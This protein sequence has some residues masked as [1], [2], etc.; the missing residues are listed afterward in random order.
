M[1]LSLL[2]V[3]FPEVRISRSFE[4]VR[5]DVRDYRGTLSAVDIA[6]GRSPTVGPAGI[7]DGTGHGTDGPLAVTL[8]IRR[9]H[10]ASW[11][12][13]G[14]P[15]PLSRKPVTESDWRQRLRTEQ[16]RTENQNSTGGCGTTST[17]ST[18]SRMGGRL[19]GATEQLAALG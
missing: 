4:H 15:S 5:L 6:T 11:A 7:E 9:K 13:L 12:E 3:A 18:R 2:P 14:A 8:M 16:T 19:D 1:Q 10:H 17:S